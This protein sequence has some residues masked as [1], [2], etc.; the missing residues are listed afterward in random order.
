MS[1]DKG[2]DKPTTGPDDEEQTNLPFNFSHPESG[3]VDAESETMV[4]DV[5][6]RLF[7]DK[8]E[9]FQQKALLAMTERLVQHL[10]L[11]PIR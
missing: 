3:A 5:I 4:E 1:K 2:K 8:P 9:D 11:P 10:G 6:K 7:P